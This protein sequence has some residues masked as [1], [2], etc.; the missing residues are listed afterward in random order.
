MRWPFHGGSSDKDKDKERTPRTT[1]A[2][3]FRRRAKNASS[4][5]PASTACVDCNV[6]DKTATYL[7]TPDASQEVVVEV[8][9]GR[10]QR[11]STKD[12]KIYLKL[13]VKASEEFEVA[14]MVEVRW[15]QRTS[16]LLNV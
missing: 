10:T 2:A 3:T 1:R 8:S 12:Y 6:Y 5:R 7:R 16:T 13:K 11:T 15:R 4:R 9:G 14:V